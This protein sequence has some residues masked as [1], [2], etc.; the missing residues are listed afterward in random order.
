MSALIQAS[1]SSLYVASAR[2]S[3]GVGSGV[4][5]ITHTPTTERMVIVLQAIEVLI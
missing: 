4:N 2:R 5:K 3:C 1:S